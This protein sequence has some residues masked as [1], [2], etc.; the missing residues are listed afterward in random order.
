MSN[1]LVSHQLSIS[2]MQMSQL[3]PIVS[4][5]DSLGRDTQIGLMGPG[6]SNPMSQ[7]QETPNNHVGFLRATPGN[8]GSH[9]FSM[10]IVQS[11]QIDSQASG[12]GT[13]QL[14]APIEQPMQMEMRLNS[15]VPKQLSTMPK[16][17][18]A[19]EP[20][21]VS[22][23]A[24]NKRVAQMDRPWLQQPNTSHKGSVQMHPL[25]NALGLQ[26]LPASSKRKT[27]M[28]SKYGKSGTPRSL[29]SKNQNAQVQQSSKIRTESSESVRSKM[30]ESLA[31]AL[32]LVSQHSRL[33]DEKNNT[34]NETGNSQV[35]LDNSSQC[36]SSAT[37]AAQG[38]TQ[39]VPRSVDSYSSVIDSFDN[40]EY[41]H[42]E[43]GCTKMLNFPHDLNCDKQDFQSSYTLTTDDVPFSDT[44][45]VKD[46]LLQGNGLSWV[47]DSDMVDM[48]ME[49]EIQTNQDQRLEPDDVG[50]SVRK[51]TINSPEL[52][53]SEIEAELFKLF[54]GVNKKYKEKGRSLLF[55]LKDRNNPE[56][57][58]KVMS[59]EIP[60]ERLCS[61]T[62]EELAS[63]E[64]SQW[65]IAKAEELAQMVVLP[66]SDVDIRR[67]VR[68]THKGEFQV[69]VEHEDNPSVEVSG[70]K[71]LVSQSQTERKDVEGSPSK[72]DGIKH[73]VTADVGKSNLRKDNSSTVSVPSNDGAVTQGLT[74]DDALKDVD[75]LPPI[76][77]LD[78][79]MGSLHSTKSSVENTV[80]EPGKTAPTVEKDSPVVGTV[81]RSGHAGNAPNK[82][83]GDH[84]TS[85]SVD[86]VQEKEVEAESGVIPPET[87]SS[88]SHA[89]VRPSDAHPEVR[90]TVDK[91]IADKKSA[92]PRELKAS[93]SLAEE[94]SGGSHMLSKTS[95]STMISKSEFAWQGMLQL[96]I[97]TT[98]SVISIFKS[99]E[100]TSLK[101]WAGFL[102]IKGRVRLDAFEKFLQEL[103]MSRTRAIMVMHF[104]SKEDCPENEKPILREVADSYILDERVGFA[105]PAPGVELY[106]CPPHNKTVE[107]L[108]KILPMEQIEAVNSID[109]GLIGINVWRKTH[110]TSTISPTSSSHHKHS[111]KKQYL[112]TRR[113]QD[114]NVNGNL[115]P[116]AETPRGFANTQAGPP[117]DDDIP[118]GFGPPVVRDEDDLPEFN[119]SGGS[120]PSHSVHKPFIRPAPSPFHSTSQTSHAVEQ[121]RE[122][123]QKYG[124]SQVNA[125]GNWHDDKF[126]ATIQPWNDEDDDIPEWQPQTSQN[127]F[128]PQHNFQPP[129]HTLNHSY[130]A[131]QSFLQAPMNMTPDQSNFRPVMVPPT[132][133]SNLQPP[134]LGN[135]YGAPAQA[136]TW[137]QNVPRTRDF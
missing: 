47:L 61:M 127:Q 60:P 7:Q 87:S 116:K 2:S 120:N 112:S 6:S 62:A 91:K 128:H 78:E 101:D 65:R 81:P 113:Q 82:S 57:R 104:V 15:T 31:A 27:Q 129:P 92:S 52:L 83:D 107:M 16:R 58:E 134:P 9:G 41:A 132:Q 135:T 119:F 21:S 125:S 43:I 54:G 66:D 73:D 64:L 5:V 90:S 72:A 32:D 100:K 18:A 85:S 131:S 46:E 45:F 56:L 133:R 10:P 122:L 130:G 93:Q 25:S 71:T 98:H 123:V 55:N 26:N 37:D 48:P 44:F 97:S 105:E 74:A 1:N 34:A 126:G 17:K 121:M 42:S 111:S 136:P 86:A 68:K 19:T 70:G 59:G 124:Q 51:Q 67:L 3:D 29:S 38:Q 23:V 24:S 40:V 84:K 8:P 118:P 108:S 95:V 110:S 103:P 63:K 49:Q 79:F 94:K 30:R 33:Q 69:E 12:S 14:V 20:L 99:G 11:G 77:S 22:S 114:T 76:V 39:E 109:Y 50:S 36:S 137:H 4:K 80:V 102:E 28:E 115:A 96:N 106:F 35:K 75:F 117:D 89:G 53:A 13:H 88:R